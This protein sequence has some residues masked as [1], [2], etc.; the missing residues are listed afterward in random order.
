MNQNL[1]AFYK[2][3]RYLTETEKLDYP[4]AYKQ[5]AQAV[6]D[7][8]GETLDIILTQ[9]QE[10]HGLN[11]AKDLAAL[12]KKRDEA[13]AQTE[14]QAAIDAIQA[15][16]NDPAQ[17]AP[18][19]RY[20]RIE[21][22]TATLKVTNVKQNVKTA[23][24]VYCA[25]YPPLKIVIPHLISSGL[26]ILAGA[27]K[28][29]KSWLVLSWAGAAANSGYLFGSKEMKA[30]KC[31]TLYISMEDTERSLNYRMHIL[32]QQDGFA[33]SDNLLLATD[34]TGGTAAL[35]AFLSQNRQIQF[36]I[37]D[38]LGMFADIQD[39]NDYTETRTKVSA[40]KR[41]ADDFD[42]AILAVHHAKKGAN[43][44]GSAGGDWM[45]A[46]LGSQGLVGTSDATFILQRPD[47]D[48]FE[49]VIRSTGRSV[50]DYR[51]NLVMQDGLWLF[52]DEQ[53]EVK[54]APKRKNKA[55]RVLTMEDAKAIL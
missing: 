9:A 27:P 24:Q 35:R 34:W 3:F 19:D 36:V 14:A 33:S 41:I 50:I 20:H 1:T 18:L 10:M 46:A 49:G 11:I 6:D 26:T 51:A 55:P 54:Q 42:I 40:I 5:A 16:I 43:A 45:D 4:T 25:V 28:I 39:F 23:A 21:E 13:L 31:P 22:L 38:T 48:K 2:H 44:A 8:S 30:A 7:L 47:R 15:A 17:T 52:S 12:T 32:Q 53:P 37:I 29:G